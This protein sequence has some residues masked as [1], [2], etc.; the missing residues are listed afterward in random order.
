MVTTL[1]PTTTAG[2]YSHAGDN[3]TVIGD[4]A[5]VI[6]IVIGLNVVSVITIVIYHDHDCDLS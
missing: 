6:F 2:P 1:P 4:G 5:L 3:V